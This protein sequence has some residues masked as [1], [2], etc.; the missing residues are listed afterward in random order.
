MVTTANRDFR[1]K[2]RSQQTTGDT[3]KTAPKPFYRSWTFLLGI[4]A[5][6]LVVAGGTA[7]YVVSSGSEET[8]DVDWDE[9]MAPIPALQ[10]SERYEE[11]IDHFAEVKESM[12]TTE[13]VDVLRAYA[14]AR[15]M[16]SEEGN[17]HVREAIQVLRRV[18][19]LQPD[20]TATVRQLFQLY[21]SMSD[22][23]LAIQ[24]GDRVL[25]LDPEDDRSMVELGD[26]LV[27][28]DQSKRS[29]DLANTAID[30]K[31]DNINAYRVAIRGMLADG[32]SDEDI[33]NWISEKVSFATARDV[34]LDTNSLMLLYARESN[35]DQLAQIL[36]AKVIEAPVSGPDNARF[37]AQ[38]LQ[39]AGDT[40]ASTRVLSE[41]LQASEEAG[42]A[43]AGNS[44]TTDN[45]AISL[46]YRQLQLGLYDELLQLI[47]DNFAGT[48]RYD[49]RILGVEFLANAYSGN[50]ESLAALAEQMAEYDTQFARVWQP[51]L[52]ELS[53]ETMNGKRVIELTTSALETFPGSAH[54]RYWQAIGY[55]AAG[56]TDIAI[57]V[58]R[59]TTR[60]A[61]G[62]VMPRLQLARL[63]LARGD[64]ERA[65]FESA[66]ALRAN[67]GLQPAIDYV[68]AAVVRLQADGR[69]IPAGLSE[70]VTKVIQSIVESPKAGP[71]R[72]LFEAIGKKLDGDDQGA[73]RLLAQYFE[74]APELSVRQY[75]LLS[76][77]VVDEALASRIEARSSELYGMTVTDLLR[78]AEAV[79]QTDGEEAGLNFM[80]NYSVN[81]KPLDEFTYRMAACQLLS[82]LESDQAL[83]TWMKFAE[84][85]REFPRVLKEALA[86]TVVRNEEEARTTLI[87]WMRDCYEEG[88]DWQLEEIALQ[89]EQ[90][91]SEKVAAAALVRLDEL[92]PRAPSNPTAYGLMVVAYERIGQPAKAVAVLQ[93]AIQVGAARP[94]YFLRAAQLLMSQEEEFLAVDL[95][96]KLVAQSNVS[97]D[98]LIAA[99]K[100]LADAREYSKA[101]AAMKT[102]LPEQWADTDDDFALASIYAVNAV[103][104]GKSAD[105]YQQILPLA[106]SSDRWFDLYLSLTNLETMRVSKAKDWL[107]Q[108]AEW[109]GESMDRW[110][111]L[112]AA[113][114][115]LAKRVALNQ[116]PEY[117]QLAV[118]SMQEVVNRDPTDV[119]F[120]QFANLYERAGDTESAIRLYQEIANSDRPVEFRA[121]A[122]NNLAM[123]TEDAASAEGFIR[124][125]I[126]LSPQADYVDTLAMILTRQDQQADAIK[127]LET[128]LAD[129]PENV[130]LQ[131]RLAELLL[132]ASELERANDV[133]AK[134]VQQTDQSDSLKHTQ[135]QQI[136]ELQ[137]RYSRMQAAAKAE[138]AAQAAAE[139]ATEDTRVQPVGG[140]AN[141][142]D[143]QPSI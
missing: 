100:V 95:A 85:Y 103:Q 114:R 128:S 124:S 65:L 94:E 119:D 88:I 141:V 105:V 126:E 91:E 75:N 41:A 45:I 138:E 120:I 44:L 49:E 113:W 92:Q 53:Q 6:L 31:P 64:L 96:Q 38:Q 2:T 131:I 47:Q 22:D 133:L 10:T 129:Y 26:L 59:Q 62:W 19:S 97:R 79:A 23:D 32:A 93:K 70:P 76:D 89:L 137:T 18:D 51:L 61:S 1:S 20:D 139:S 73:D 13:R 21:T 17:A 37:V 111:N 106:Q 63:F 39:Q 78:A 5:V 30:M 25:E 80:K 110:R 74:N 84:D 142:S 130:V 69:E 135:W 72:Q 107:T 140:S 132:N 56:E 12:P 122:L 121:F 48:E 67:P 52:V 43:D 136:R 7:V 81:G 90:D 14:D 123:L 11:I 108:A 87:Q 34:P 3:G 8:V 77:M 125:A 15:L 16:V 68:F 127:L 66:T 104:A 42:I 4:A 36:L 40:I 60:V 134:L 117:Y 102:V 35:D 29:V 116:R 24:Y 86:A 83:E 27:E 50:N 109:G 46:L 118:D 112:S 28:A 57:K 143:Q 115:S 55:E 101:T 98:N 58:L 71:E 54:L 82:R 9:V 99:V 33:T